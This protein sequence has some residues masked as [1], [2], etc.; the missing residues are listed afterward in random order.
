M[1]NKEEAFTA[2]K[3]AIYCYIH[4]NNPA[5]YEGI[6]EAGERT[7]RAMNTIINNANNSNETKISSTIKINKT[8]GEWKQDETEKQYLSKVF[9]VVANSNIKDYTIG[10]TK[11]NARRYW[12]YKNN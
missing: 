9:Q 10:I 7:L 3:H 5:D 11:E 12:R 2:T 4:G 1:A 6:G 8:E